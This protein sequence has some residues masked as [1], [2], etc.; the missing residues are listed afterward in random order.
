MNYLYLFSIGFLYLYISWE[1]FWISSKGSK[2]MK[3]VPTCH[4]DLQMMSP[5]NCFMIILQ[6]CNPRPMPFVFNYY[7]ASKNPNILNSF[8]WSFFLI[9]IPESSTIISTTPCFAFSTISIKFCSSGYDKSSF[10]LNSFPLTLT[11]PPLL[12]NLSELDNKFRRI[13]ENLC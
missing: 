6:M 13:W 4:F 2:K 9:P 10:W 1:L 11:K 3:D 12:V 7:V 8:Y 5:P